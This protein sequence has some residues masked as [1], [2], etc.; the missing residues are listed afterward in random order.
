MGRLRR[1]KER[2]QTEVGERSQE[3]ECHWMGRLKEANREL[4][5]VSKERGEL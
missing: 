2:L 4:L 3:E 5:R 1:E